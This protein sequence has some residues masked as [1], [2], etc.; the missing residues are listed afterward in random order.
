MIPIVPQR[1]A[2][3]AA[4]STDHQRHD[5]VLAGVVLVAGWEGLA[6]M[7]E[8]S[9]DGMNARQLA[10]A[11]LDAL[12]RADLAAMLTLFSDGAQVYSPLYGPM[13]ASDF[14]PALFTDTAES[15]LTLHG[16]MHGSAANGTPLASVWFEFGW[17]L[18]GGRQVRFD[19][20]DVIELASDSHIASIRIVYDTAPIRPVF[21]EQT[22]QRSWRGRWRGN[23]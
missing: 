10:E 1:P 11:Y 15:R 4:T 21:E 16:V 13:P 2:A 14:Y 6:I 17:Q 20:V 18:A 23:D 7:A 8:A 22:G 19:V 9:G 5:R 3:A 12:G